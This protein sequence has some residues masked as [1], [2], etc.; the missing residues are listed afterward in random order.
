MI[1]TVNCVVAAAS[2]TD[3]DSD[4]S[5]LNGT[6]CPSYGNWTEPRLGTPRGFLSNGKNISFQSCGHSESVS[7]NRFI[8]YVNDIDYAQQVR[9]SVH[10]RTRMN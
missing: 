2:F 3:N 5:Q 1:W 4:V 8:F 9:I 6:S 7:D 10:C